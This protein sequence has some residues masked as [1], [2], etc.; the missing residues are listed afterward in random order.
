MLDG[1]GLEEGG[2][3]EQRVSDTACLPLEIGGILS[4]GNYKGTGPFDS[5]I[6]GGGPPEIACSS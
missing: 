2:G 4:R 1:L 3:A 5:A 6:G